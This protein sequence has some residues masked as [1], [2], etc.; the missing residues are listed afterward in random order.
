MI[1]PDVTKATEDIGRDGCRGA[2]LSAEAQDKT[3]AEATTDGTKT[4]RIYN[5]NINAVSRQ[6]KDRI[7]PAIVIFTLA[8]DQNVDDLQH[9]LFDTIA[10]ANVLLDS[11]HQGLK[12]I[13]GNYDGG[14]NPLAFLLKT[15]PVFLK[16]QDLTDLRDALIDR[17]YPLPLLNLETNVSRE[18]HPKLT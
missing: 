11:Q 10:E 2:S 15:G 4:R 12:D 16:S 14:A 7:K 9:G 8:Q 17:V 13:L 6:E 18:S 3:R 5:V 1:E